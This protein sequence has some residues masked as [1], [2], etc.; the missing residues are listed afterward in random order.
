MIFSKPRALAIPAM[1][2]G[3]NNPAMVPNIDNIHEHHKEKQSKFL[4]AIIQDTG[5]SIKPT[6]NSLEQRNR[7]YDSIKLST[8]STFVKT[9]KTPALITE[10]MAARE[11][12]A[13]SHSAMYGT[14]RE[15]CETD[16]EQIL[17]SLN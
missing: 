8:I 11:A 4:M 1:R 17:F 15:S 12:I 16:A 3:S 5:R 9:V 14:M 7:E 13:I 2:N 10:S 6:N